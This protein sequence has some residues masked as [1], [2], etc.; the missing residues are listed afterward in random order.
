MMIQPPCD[1]VTV[2][3]GNRSYDIIIGNGILPTAG[4]WIKPL[5]HHPRVIIVTDENV[6]QHHLSTLENALQSVEISADCITVPA[7]EKSKSTSVFTDL[8]EQVLALGIDRHSTLIALGGGVVG[9]LV[10]Y[11][12]ASLLRGI[13]FIQIPTTLLAQVDSSV[14]GKTGINATAGKNLIGAFHQPKLVLID[15]ATLDTLP[16]RDVRSGY[17]EVAKYGAIDDENFFAWLERHGESVIAG[18]KQNR[19][20][21]IKTSIQAKSR[22]VSA[23]EQERG[24]R[25]LLNLGHTFAH[26]LENT[27]SYD[28]RLTHGE[29]VSI[30]MVMAH[31]LSVKMGLCGADTAHRITRHLQQVGLPVSL[32]HVP[33][34]HWNANDLTALMA[35]DKKAIGGTLT[36]IL[37][38][39]IGQAFVSHDVPTEPVLEILNQFITSP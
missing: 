23:D 22:V 10:G 25:A 8:C 16:P 2:P 39:G 6:A 4:H 5:L 34:V 15:G 33:D 13:D 9:D 28:N 29:A 24:M 35:R 17:A 38:R 21:A 27:T 37:S 20:Y 12:A 18:D 36:F 11:V 32:S 31:E 30:G 1:V 26:A 3:L 19:H 14:G 7:G